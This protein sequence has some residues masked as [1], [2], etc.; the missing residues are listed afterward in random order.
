MDVPAESGTERFHLSSVT[1]GGSEPAHFY[2]SLIQG[3]QTVKADD[4]HVF[5]ADS[6]FSEDMND[7]GFIYI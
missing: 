2:T 1:C 4:E 7:K 5:T 6:H 3:Q